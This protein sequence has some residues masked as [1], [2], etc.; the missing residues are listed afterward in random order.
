[1]RSALESCANCWRV[2]AATPGVMVNAI[3][4]PD[5]VDP[6]AAKSFF[7]ALTFAGGYGIMVTKLGPPHASLQR[8]GGQGE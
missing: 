6:L 1:M 5:S 4:L 7:S 2:M 3:G 8:Q